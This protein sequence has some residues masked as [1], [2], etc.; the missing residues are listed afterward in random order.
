MMI[1]SLQPRCYSQ[2]TL[3]RSA[4]ALA[5]VT[6]GL[7]GCIINTDSHS[8]YSGKYISQQTLDQV[9]PG[10]TKEFVLAVLGEPSTKTPLSDGT[11][12]WKWRYR[13]T[14]R[15]SGSVLFVFNGDS[16][17]ETETATY[18]LFNADLVTETWRD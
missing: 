15:S 8:Q 16:T 6:L 14:K 13:N 18:V 5:L 2:A 4:T 7:C 12:I 17:T 3:S 11:E 10:K 1:P 9:S